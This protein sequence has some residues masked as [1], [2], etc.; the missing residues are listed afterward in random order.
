MEWPYF[1]YLPTPKETINQSGNGIHQA[2]LGAVIIGIVF[3]VRRL[4]QPDI[5][6]QLDESGDSGDREVAIADREDDVAEN[7]TID[8][9]DI[10]MFFQ[11]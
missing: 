10:D 7:M 3:A 1:S 6:D 2:V 9:H 11:C 8:M 4:P 5:D